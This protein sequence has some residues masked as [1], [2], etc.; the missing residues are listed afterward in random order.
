MDIVTTR[1]DIV[2]ADEGDLIRIPEGLVG[3]RQL[4]QYV[5]LPDPEAAG[6]IWLQA[7]EAADVAFALVPPSLI[8]NDYRI[9]LRPGDRAAIELDEERAAHVYVILNR[10]ESGGLTANLQGPLVFNL[11]RRI[12]RQ[13]VLTSS[14]YAV[15]FPLGEGASA[16]APGP[17]NSDREPALVGCGG[18]SL[19][20]LA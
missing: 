19:R 17:E 11:G 3:F 12:A 5:L 9:E 18:P 6:L 20:I 13:L 15:R 10:S 1:F 4:T 16:P 7:V 8:V 14:R 2:P